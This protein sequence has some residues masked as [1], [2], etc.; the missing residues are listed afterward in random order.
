MSPLIFICTTNE[1]KLDELKNLKNYLEEMGYEVL[2]ERDCCSPLGQLAIKQKLDGEEGM[3]LVCA[4]GLGRDAFEGIIHPEN[5]FFSYSLEEDPKE[6]ANTIHTEVTLVSHEKVIDL[7][8]LE[9]VLVIGGGVGGVFAALD[10]AD[11]GYPVFMVEKDPSI[12]G[13]MAALDKTFPT[14]DCSI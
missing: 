12:G 13:I 2:M 7:K 6:L 5:E 8:P 11:Q 4:R 3:V 1:E 14:M 10:I 9:K